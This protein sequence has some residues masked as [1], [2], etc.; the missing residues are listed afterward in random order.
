MP[1]KQSLEECG[2]LK[3]SKLDRSRARNAV[4]VVGHP[5]A[6]IGMG[7]H[8]R[9]VYR[10]VREAGAD[11]KLVDIYGPGVNADQQLISTYRQDI[12]H[13]LGDAINIFCING[14]E[15]E[16]AFS[17]LR[18]RNILAPGSKNVIYPAWELERYPEEWARVLD[19]FDEIWA[20]SQFIADALRNAAQVPVIHMPLACEIE[21]RALLSRRFFSIP[22]SAYTFFFAFDFLSY[23]ERKNPYAVLD[24][25]Q[26]VVDARPHADVN[27]VIKVNNGRARPDAWA[28]FEKHFDSYGDQVT[29]IN[30][31]LS[32]LEMK[33]LLWNIDCF[34]SLHRSE[35][36]GRGMTE[37]MVLGKPVIATA[38]SG[39][40]DFC[41][42]DTAYLIPY[43]QVDVRPGE[44]PHWQRQQWADADVEAASKAMLQ[45]VD[46]PESGRAKGAAARAVMAAEFSFLAR[47]L[48]YVER[49]KTLVTHE[50]LSAA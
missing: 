1:R 25:F 24:A 31:T 20:P 5:S 14:D 38:Y 13:D 33:A 9:S 11:C 30:E 35:G 6:P 22:E 12:S 48:D 42:P 4:H 7:E 23:I 40:L 36:F 16:Q 10:A 28:S 47:G 41:R 45:L 19:G 2:P 29:I 17:V 44:Y 49:A 32:D 43:K 39:N 18:D 3:S 26:R 46:A 50:A 27:L 15:V 34:V 37:A 8:S 21:G